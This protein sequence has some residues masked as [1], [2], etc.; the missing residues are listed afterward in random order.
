MMYRRRLPIWMVSA[1]LLLTTLYVIG[2]CNS[3]PAPSIAINENTI[4]DGINRLKSDV[5]GPIASICSRGSEILNGD[6]HPAMAYIYVADDVRRKTC[7]SPSSKFRLD[8]PIQED[9]NSV[10]FAVFQKDCHKTFPSGEEALQGL[11]TVSPK[12]RTAS[13]E[14]FAAHSVIGVPLVEF[15]LQVTMNKMTKSGLSQQKVPPIRMETNVSAKISYRA[16][17]VRNRGRRPQKHSAVYMVVE[18]IAVE[19]WAP[20][21]PTPLVSSSATTPSPSPASASDADRRGVQTGN[22]EL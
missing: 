13:I 20:G 9:T 2:S 22:D 1:L 18:S 10:A 8:Y 16:T 4:I 7:S 5:L 19:E 3:A 15:C 12:L 11:L 17:K 21:S 6:T 14:F